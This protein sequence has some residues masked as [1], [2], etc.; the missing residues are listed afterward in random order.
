[1]NVFALDGRKTGFETHPVVA[2]A[3]LVRAPGCGPGGR[4]FEPHQ[5]P[6]QKN[7]RTECNITETTYLSLCSSIPCILYKI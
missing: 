4:G 7:T 5:P 3:Q 6:Q 2:V 1:M